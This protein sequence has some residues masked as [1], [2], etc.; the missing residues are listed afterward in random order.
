M[1]SI[2]ISEIGGIFLKNTLMVAVFVIAVM[3]NNP[4]VFSQN[5]PEVD[6]TLPS[7]AVVV[8]DTITADIY[9]RNGVNIAGAD[10]GITV[11]E[12]LKIIERTQGSYLPDA[13]NGGFEAF[14]ELTEESTRFALAITDRTKVANGDGIFLV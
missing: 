3:L 12:C 9:I 5:I 2:A 4:P 11:G 13:A 6:V 8:G 10:I 1:N 7:G 14:Q